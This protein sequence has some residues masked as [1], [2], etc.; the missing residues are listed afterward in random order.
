M[1]SKP[2]PMLT[3]QEFE[4]VLGPNG[5]NWIPYHTD[6]LLTLS[7]AYNEFKCK[8]EII[9]RDRVI[10]N[11]LI[12]DGLLLQALDAHAEL[13]RSAEE[14][15]HLMESFAAEGAKESEA[16]GN[17]CSLPHTVNSYS[18]GKILAKHNGTSPESPKVMV[19][20]CVNCG[21]QAISS[22][23]DRAKKLSQGD[24]LQALPA[25]PA[26]PETPPK[27]GL[28][29]VYG[30]DGLPRQH[31]VMQYVDYSTKVRQSVSYCVHCDYKRKE[32]I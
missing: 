22:A 11:K 23:L 19:S 25:S 6:D 21:W 28:C 26:V 12:L 18:N 32:P 17:L 31:T 4:A 14:K 1:S 9:Q 13:L 8:L 7:W 24:E 29:R 15:A 3:V 2:T 27:P 30:K 16:L 10:P 5:L 20:Y